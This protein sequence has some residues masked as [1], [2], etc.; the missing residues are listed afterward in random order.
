MMIKVS[1]YIAKRLA[2]VYGVRHVFLISGG[3]AMH[4]NDSFGKQEGLEY[5]CN[6]HEQA[7]AI[8]AEGYARYNQELAV[9]NVT[10]GP[11]GINTFN[12]V[13]GQ[14]TD[15]VPVLYISGQVKY[16][17]TLASFSHLGL[18]QLGDQEADIIGMVKPITKFATMLIDPM[19]TKKILDEAIYLA[20]NG[21]NGPVWID[22]PLNVQGA[23]IDEN[24][25]EDFKPPTLIDKRLSE[26]DSSLV[27]LL[28]ALKQSKR[29]L[30]VVGHGVR[31]SKTEN[32]LY[33]L[34][35]KL[36]IPAVTTFNGFDILPND[37]SCF[38]GRIGTIGQRAGNF[39]LQNADLVI[40]LGTRN[41]IR[42]ISYNWACYAKNAKK[43][44][45]DIDKAELEKPTL[46]PD[47]TINLDLKSFM[48]TLLDSLSNHPMNNYHDW[49]NWCQLSKSK[50]CP[51]KN[52]DYRNKGNLINPYFFI[53]KLTHLMKEGDL[54]T[55]GNGSACVCL[56]Q[57]GTVKKNQR[58]FWNSGN[59]SMGYD[60][61]AAIGLCIA[62]DKQKTICL[63]GDGSL[64][65]NLQELQ[66][67]K[68]Y[69]LPIKLFVMNN[70][71]Y[72][73]IKQTQTNFFEGRLAGSDKSSGVSMPNFVELA[74][75]FGLPAVR[76]ESPESLMQHLPDVLDHQGPIVCEVILDSDYIFSPKLSSEKL[77]DGRM[78]SKPL[79]DMY[80]LL[81]RKEF[82]E[83]M[84]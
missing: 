64:M 72:I 8:A 36:N 61:P 38:I 5:I 43:I 81:E 29:P 18:R 57:A 71:G 59:A 17:T 41:N 31:L 39:S 58:I 3:G 25:L 15:S 56:F 46:K 21:R 4:L 27:N 33:A 47:L 52:T 76:I 65:M 69:N 79:E 19:D 80:P 1:D 7:S 51:E 6:H 48:P 20:T 82:A 50:Y 75:A 23:L 62:A 34:L 66:T 78:V 16:E 13:F 77:A 84:L 55:A 73:S 37:H 53:Q 67:M 10:T 28:E 24:H 60:L 14:W 30:F 68:H 12:G 49:L 44:V 45:V 83:N 32:L 26:T 54:A 42:Q 22:I 63:A 70:N 35:D 40:F 11:G 9:V 74:K 2:T